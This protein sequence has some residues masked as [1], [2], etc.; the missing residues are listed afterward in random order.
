[1]VKFPLEIRPFV[2]LNLGSLGEPL[3]ALTG[4]GSMVPLSGGGGGS[5][6][7]LSGGGGGSMVPLRSGGRALVAL[8]GGGRALVALSGGGGVLVK[9]LASLLDVPFVSFLGAKRRASLPSSK[10]AVTMAMRT[11]AKV[12]NLL[13]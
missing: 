1:L 9:F 10:T 8:S 6:V 4:G 3:V 2:E 5:M 7:P 11:T 12:S 13:G